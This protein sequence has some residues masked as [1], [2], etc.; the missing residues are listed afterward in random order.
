MKNKPDSD[1]YWWIKTATESASE[2]AI[3]NVSITE[4]ETYLYHDG[5]Q[6]MWSL[7]PDI[8]RGNLQFIKAEC[9][10]FD[11]IKKII[12]IEPF[13]IDEIIETLR[14]LPHDKM[15]NISL[16]DQHPASLAAKRRGYEKAFTNNLMEVSVNLPGTKNILIINVD[17]LVCVT[18]DALYSGIY[19]QF[20][21]KFYGTENIGGKQIPLFN[22]SITVANILFIM[23]QVKI[24]KSEKPAIEYLKSLP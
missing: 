8:A 1:G 24:T 10:F 16:R 23:E 6:T 15:I 3:V 19:G 4:K 22:P 5:E 18:M 2:A 13:K 7:I 9:P 20:Q 17:P 14:I 12:S 21:A 11:E